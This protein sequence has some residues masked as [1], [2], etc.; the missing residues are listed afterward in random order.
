MNAAT[1]QQ[2]PQRTAF[3]NVYCSQCGN[4]FGPGV[5][6]FSSCKE[7]RKPE[8]KFFSNTIGADLRCVLDVEEDRLNY[9]FGALNPGIYL[10]EIWLGSVE[11]GMHLNDTT[12]KC[13][14]AEARIAC[15]K[16]A[17]A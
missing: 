17:A 2:F 16:E 9:M 12:E 15:A 14:L 5:S 7:H 13:I 3:S 1:V 10:E 4:S 6:G 11:L 8:I